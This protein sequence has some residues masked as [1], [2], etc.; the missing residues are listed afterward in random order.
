MNTATDIDLEQLPVTDLKGVGKRKA[1]QL[2]RL[3]ICNLQDLLFHLPLH[4]QDRTR[5]TAVRDLRHGMSVVVEVEVESAEIRYGRRRSLLCRTNDAGA[6]LWLRFFHFSNAQRLSL[7]TGS[8]LRCFG[9]VRDGP[10]GP[11]MIHPEYS[12][13]TDSRRRQ[14]KS[15]SRRSILPPRVCNRAVSGAWW[16]RPWRSPSRQ[17]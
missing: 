15:I 17:V 5:V 11:E 7:A 16:N 3:G 9:E 10:F 8:R 13:L 1:E 4:Y 14:W 6:V 12:S 2:T